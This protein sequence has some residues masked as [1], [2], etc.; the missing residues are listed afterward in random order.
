MIF[1]KKSTYEYT[2]ASSVADALDK[3][4]KNELGFTSQ[5]SITEELWNEVK[6]VAADNLD[7]ITYID[8]LNGFIIKDKYK[9]VKIVSAYQTDYEV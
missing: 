6:A 4:I 3:Y 1:N 2:A 8:F 9:V 7:S 5:F